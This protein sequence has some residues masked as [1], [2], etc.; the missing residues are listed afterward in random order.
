MRFQS[1]IIT[2][3]AFTIG[4]SSASGLELKDVTF[5]TAGAGKVAFSHNTHLKINA[6]RTTKAGCKTCHST[7]KP[8][9]LRYSMADLEKGKSCGACHNGRTAF[10]VAKCTGCHQVRE[11][12]Y[13]VKQTGPVHFSHARHLKTMQCNA[14]HTEL[15][16][17]G[18]NFTVSM[19]DMKKGKSCGACHNGAKAFSI[20]KCA[21]CHPTKEIAF[22]VKETGITVFSH[23]RH[24][25]GYQCSACH[26]KL[27]AVGPN[28]HVSMTAMEKGKSCG[29]CHDGKK[30]FAVAACVKCHPYEDINFK[31]AQA[32]NV[33]FSHAS[34]LGMYR[35]GAC[36][37]GTYPLRTGNRPVSMA[38][39][40]KAKSCGA[41]HDGSTAFSVGGNCDSCHARS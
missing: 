25:K 32:K 18:K 34:H 21:G 35:C 14:C 5:N 20:S 13:Q 12:T 41:C 8:T 36:H 3:A 30:A 6:D 38:E 33:K 15:Y 29:A 23:K 37:T 1:M 17:T 11:I 22:Q 2:L 40:K 28:K 7:A 26:T 39:M 16:A 9:N 10:T 24:L 19:A 27:Y 31:I 4:I